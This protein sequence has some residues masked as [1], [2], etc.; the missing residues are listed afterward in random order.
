MKRE[1]KCCLYCKKPI[2][3]KVQTLAEQFCN[4]SYCKANIKLNSKDTYL[5]NWHKEIIAYDL[6]RGKDEKYIS[7]KRNTSMIQAYEVKKNLN[8]TDY[9]KHKSNLIKNYIENGDTIQEIVAK[10]NVRSNLIGELIKLS[11]KTNRKKEIEIKKE[12]SLPVTHLD[13]TIGSYVDLDKYR[14]LDLLIPMRKA[15]V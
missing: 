8:K 13:E 9:A 6:L 15:N 4:N 1:K 2:P 3:R 11:K 5:N 10:T 14:E 12:D 7:N